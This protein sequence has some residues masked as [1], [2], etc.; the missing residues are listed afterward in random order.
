MIGRG[1]LRNRLLIYPELP[2]CSDTVAQHPFF[3]LEML[4]NPP[5]FSWER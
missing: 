2:A 5:T 1:I 4:Q 3:T